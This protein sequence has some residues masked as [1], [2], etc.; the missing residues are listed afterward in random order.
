M[1]S[2]KLYG[3]IE[4]GGTKFICIVAGGPDEIIEEARFATTTP[5]QTLR[6]VCAFFRPFAGQKRLHSIGLGTF[7][8]LDLD[9]ASPTYGYITST[10]KPGWGGTNILGI[11]QS[12]LGVRV[13]MDV[14]VAASA[15]GEQRW[16]ASQGHDPSLYLTVG[17]G[18]GGCYLAGGKPLRGMVGSEMGHVRIP[19]HRQADP[20]DG[21]CPYHGDCFEGLA[22]GPSIQERFGQPAE[23][24]ADDHPFWELEAGYIAAAL[25]NTILT[26]SPRKIVLG[27]GVMQR[28][29]LFAKIRRRV[30]ELL[31]GYLS[32][33]TLT[34]PMDEYIVPPALGHRSGVLGGVA[35]AMQLEQSN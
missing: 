8:P 26:F 12:A 4:G 29:F 15:L 28:A 5:Q 35:M 9:P 24:L 10:P 22:S 6:Q 23:S 30:G 25:A 19:H 33:P 2:S 34:G 32:H 16:G 14:D 18:I 21:C 3:G 11:L 17:T 13:A 20:F 1:S 27:G 7:G 31:N